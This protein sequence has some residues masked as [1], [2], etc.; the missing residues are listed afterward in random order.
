M[1]RTLAAIASAVA[2][3]WVIGL[4]VAPPAAADTHSVT[5]YV[6]DASTSIPIAGAS[7]E[8]QPV[9]SN[10]GVP[11]VY[12]TTLDSGTYYFGNVP[13][14]DYRLVVGGYNYET[15]SRTIQVDDSDPSHQQVYEAF[16]LR[17][18]NSALHGT[19]VD[20]S[21]D[22]VAN[23]LVTAHDPN[24]D[25]PETGANF[26]DDSSYSMQVPPGTYDLEAEAYGYATQ[27]RSVTV[28]ASTDLVE[29]FVMVPLPTQLVSGTV[30]DARTGDPLGDIEGIIL[31]AV[32]T[33]DSYQY[34]AQFVTDD[35]GHFSV[36]VPV[37]D[38]YTIEYYD[39]LPI[40]G[41]PRNPA[42]E[43]LYLG[44][45]PILSTASTFDVVSGTDVSGK[46]IQLAPGGSISGNVTVVAADGTVGH[47][48]EGE[49][50]APVI[51]GFFDGDW[52]LM[53]IPSQRV[54]GTAPGDY[55]L[56]GFPAGQYRA[57]FVDYIP[58]VRGF[59]TVYYNNQ[60]AFDDATAFT[61]SFG[62]VTRNID[63]RIVSFAP[64]TDAFGLPDGAFTPD[65]QDRISI[66]D[67]DIRL[68]QNLHI[69]LGSA[70]VGQWVSVWL[71]SDPVQ[72]GGW[73]QVARDGTVAV[74]MGTDLGL[75]GAHDLDVQTADNEPIGWTAVTVH[76]GYPAVHLITAPHITGTFA[77]GRTL[78]A[79]VGH[80]K[81]AS[82]HF[83][84]QW[85]ADGVPVP[86]GTLA[87]VKLT[88]ADLGK[89]MSV[90]VTAT[91]SRHSL[92]TSSAKGAT[93]VVAGKLVSQTPTVS[94]K[95]VVGHTLAA[96]TG[97]WTPTS[98]HFAYQWL[99]DGKA[100]TKATASSY[101]LT[102]DDVGA[103]ITVQVTGMATGYVDKIKLSSTKVSKTSG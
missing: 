36:A 35:A 79:H 65:L 8:L 10:D 75:L 9:D 80:W 31:Q 91:S 53:D 60:D 46:D 50:I 16:T 54:D 96:A 12:G 23:V 32:T 57:E 42:Y 93:A 59:A 82:A 38:G 100:I 70:Y 67:P 85:S 56:H 20:G 37:A 69:T 61:V 102:K 6:A 71:H 78:T 103:R 21:G 47:T 76:L 2:A 41:T 87:T 94:G 45:S 14:D 3:F 52:Q 15:L 5:V 29:N 43:T 13:I 89:E 22:P 88:P 97:R 39:D 28:A 49:G 63:A 25:A 19:V 74:P 58:S 18:V 84:F 66:A 77:V 44:G 99:R 51:Y 62:H 64:V 11:A 73:V 98:T 33:A 72:L 24:P 92:A 101:L 55:A 90:V 68:G 17:H 7:L 83:H 95:R 26:S 30:T 86:K 48:W 27:H 1:R 81:P 40:G 34:S 4:L